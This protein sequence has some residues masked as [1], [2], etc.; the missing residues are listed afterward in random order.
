MGRQYPDIMP[1]ALSPS[2]IFGLALCI[3]GI[4]HHPVFHVANQRK[5]NLRSYF[6][7]REMV[8]SI[9]EKSTFLLLVPAG[10]KNGMTYRVGVAHFDALKLPR[11]LSRHGHDIPPYKY[12]ACR[13][14]KMALH[15][16]NTRLIAVI[17]EVLLFQFFIKHVDK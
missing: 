1:E 6:R 7:A 3:R 2:D 4:I 16:L 10:P 17:C 15:H 11:S 14:D 8:V 9:L 12:G 5:I 13:L